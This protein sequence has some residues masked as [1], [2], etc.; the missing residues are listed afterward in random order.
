M[1]PAELAMIETPPV[2]DLSRVASSYAVTTGV[3]VRVVKGALAEITPAPPSSASLEVTPV[4][5]D[6]VG[7]RFSE[8]PA[9]M[10]WFVP[11][12]DAGGVSCT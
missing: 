12:N 6:G 9:G 4:A 10:S 1:L 7:A 2:V 5:P 8:S 3:I 11:V